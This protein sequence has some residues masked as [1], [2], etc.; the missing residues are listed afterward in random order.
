MRSKC[1][2]PRIVVFLS[3]S[4]LII[5][6]CQLEERERLS[7]PRWLSNSN[8]DLEIKER[9]AYE[10]ERLHTLERAKELYRYACA[11]CHGLSGNGRGPSAAAL[12]TTPTDFTEG[13]FVMGESD[14]EIYVSISAG[15]PD[16]LMPPW[17]DLLSQDDLWGLVAQVKSF[18]A[19]DD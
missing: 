19:E 11:T 8:A 7:V 18:S 6:G 10:T 1:Q 4:T 12:D 17:E 9:V 3:V 2:T 15:V 13:V 5:A 14:E 16:S